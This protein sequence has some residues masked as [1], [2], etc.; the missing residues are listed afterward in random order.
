MSVPKIWPFIHPA[1]RMITRVLVQTK[2]SLNVPLNLTNTCSLGVRAVL[3][4]RSSLSG[5]GSIMS[6]VSSML[7]QVH[8]SPLK[9]SLS[10]AAI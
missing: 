7:R 10:S 8:S 6:E 4:A 3:N 1:F 9:N 5:M 2:A